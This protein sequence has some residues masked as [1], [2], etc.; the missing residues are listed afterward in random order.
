MDG[1]SFGDV[2]G[3]MRV[4]HFSVVDAP[5]FLRLVNA[6][7]FQSFLQANTLSFSRLESDFQWKLRDQ[8]DL[9]IISNGKTS[10]ASV[11]FAFD[12][13][14]DVA[15]NDMDI[16]GTAAPLSSINNFIGKIPVVGQI[17]TGGGALL[18]A[19]YEVSGN[20]DNPSV[21]VNPI[22]VLTPGIVRKMLF[23]NTPE[24]DTGTAT[25]TKTKQD[26]TT[27]SRDFN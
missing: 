20:T 4:D 9:Y 7:S 27:K 2:Q 25:G 16:Q 18:A 14:V 26:E 24:A 13:Y 21:N 10:G 17:L 1:G 8:G 22:S 15:K 12:G 6:L 3:H 19:T 11:A 23:E 5:T